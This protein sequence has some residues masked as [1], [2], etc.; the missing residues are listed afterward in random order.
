[1]LID[2][3]IPSGTA[4]R[5]HYYFLFFEEKEAA[6]HGKSVLQDSPVPDSP[7]YMHVRSVQIWF[8][9][10][11]SKDVLPPFLYEINS[12]FPFVSAFINAQT[13]HGTEDAARVILELVE[14]AYARAS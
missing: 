6:L 2:V 1:M 4:W 7:S 13:F 12:L 14:E 5:H 10:G 9:D 11:F 8:E 3:P